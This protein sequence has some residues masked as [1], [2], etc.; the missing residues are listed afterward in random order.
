[1]KGGW[2]VG[3]F[4]RV[5]YGNDGTGNGFPAGEKGVRRPGPVE[6]GKK[7]LLSCR[8]LM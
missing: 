7:T 3:G 4:A 6:D 1:M 5:V 8:R 2:R